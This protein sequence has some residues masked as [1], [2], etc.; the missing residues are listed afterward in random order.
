LC[1]HTEVP[2]LGGHIKYFELVKVHR[3]RSQVQGSTFRVEV[4][5]KVE[6]KEGI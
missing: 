6:D 5:V 1:R 3:N 2:F 4:K